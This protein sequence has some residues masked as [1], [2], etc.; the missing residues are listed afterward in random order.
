MFIQARQYYRGRRNP[1]KRIH[2][3]SME[4][5]EKGTTAESIANYFANLTERKASAHYCF[6]NNSEVQCVRDE[7]TAFHVG[8]DNSSSIGLEHAGYAR[9]TREDWLD[10]YGRDMLEISAKRCAQLC[11]EHDIPP[12]WLDFVD[13]REDQR[14]I[15]SHANAAIA[16]G[17]STHWD[18]GPGFPHDYYI[19]RVQFYYYGGEDDLTPEE[20]KL[21]FKILGDIHSALTNREDPNS[22]VKLVLE[23]TG[24]QRD[25]LAG[26]IRKVFDLPAGG[27][28][29]TK[30]IGWLRSKLG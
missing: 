13:L 17:G 15:S 5:P 1:I 2:V 6:D 19:E 3:H 10:Q 26:L 29:D 21:L 23:G 8:N 4:A 28:E 22:P 20:K 9:Q 18:P 14:G 16:F 12:V 7:D 11:H 25:T 30:F 24:R 27:T